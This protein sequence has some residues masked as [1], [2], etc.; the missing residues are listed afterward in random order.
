MSRSSARLLYFLPYTPAL[1]INVF[2]LRS[3]ISFFD[4]V[5]HHSSDYI[6]RYWVA[7]I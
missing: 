1:V 7:C 6:Y 5:L 4:N 3:S 2:Q